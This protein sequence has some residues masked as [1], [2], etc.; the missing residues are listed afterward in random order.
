M[1]LNNLAFEMKKEDRIGKYK[2][3]PFTNYRQNIVLIVKEGWR[4]RSTHTLL[5]IDVT[6]AKNLIQKYKKKNKKSISF[7]AWICKCV[8]QTMSEHKEFNSYRHGRKKYVIFDDVDIAIPVER[9]DEN[10]HRPRVYILR[11]A[12]EKSVEEIT[13]EIR[14]VQSE[15]I[16]EST[17][18]LGKNLTTLEKVALNSP[19]F[20]KKILLWVTRRNAIL[21]KRY[22]GTTGVTAIGMKG[23]FPGW[24]IPMGGTATT[25]F[26][27]G[28][29]TK[30]PGVVNDK[31]QIRE[32]LSLTLTTDHD[33][34]DGGPLVR[35]V[36]RLTGLMED[37]FDL[38]KL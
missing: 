22:M 9:N 10:E 30:K 14:S 20:F 5:E 18:L 4:K 29:I 13:D 8:A 19:M 38:D 6:N 36:E 31:T 33:L 34:I 7:T 15:K 32:F 1:R 24:V 23:K 26:V 35:F 37:G 17:Q 25:L 27:V 28:G 21:K 11:K 12:N 3:K 16:D 2:I